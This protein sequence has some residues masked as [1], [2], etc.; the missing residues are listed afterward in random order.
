MIIAFEGVDG[1]GKSTLFEKTYRYLSETYKVIK[2]KEPGGTYLGGKIREMLLSKNDISLASEVFL[3]A[4]DRAQTNMEIY[5]KY[6]IDHI[7]LTDRSVYSSIVYQGC[8][9]L[10][11]IEKTTGRI[12]DIN[13]TALGTNFPDA[14]FL[15][16]AKTEILMNRLKKR[17]SMDNIENRIKEN[18]DFYRNAYNYVLKRFHHGEQFTIDTTEDDEDLSIEVIKGLINRKLYISKKYKK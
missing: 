9:D 7:I 16:D 18:L 8:K 6:N 4:A 2:T 12:Y 5:E 1:S 14:V 10:F 15:I 13:A 11:N 3:F 17:V